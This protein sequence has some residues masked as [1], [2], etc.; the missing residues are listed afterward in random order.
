VGQT[1]SARKVQ[2][3]MRCDIKRTSQTS[4]EY[5]TQT[6]SEHSFFSAHGTFSKTKINN[7]MGAEYIKPWR[8]V[9]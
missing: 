9:N 8:L 5:S 6:A 4:T 2:N 3:S 1:K 7:K